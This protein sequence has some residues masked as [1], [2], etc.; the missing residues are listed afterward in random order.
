MTVT[1]AINNSNI[2]CDVNRPGQVT[3]HV[4]IDFIVNDVAS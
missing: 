2:L 1:I 3:S 4:A